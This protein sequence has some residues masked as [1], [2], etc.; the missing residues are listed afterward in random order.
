MLKIQLIITPVKFKKKTLPIIPVLVFALLIAACTGNKQ[1]NPTETPPAGTPTPTEAPMAAR[2]NGEGILLSDYEEELKRFQAGA[3]QSGEAYD[4][5]I[6]RQ[7]VLNFLVEQTLFAQAAV[8][9]GFDVNADGLQARLD[10]MTLARGGQDGLNIY[11]SENFYTTESFQ[12][13]ITRDLAVIW[14]RNYLIDQIPETAPQVHARQILVRTENEAIVIQRRLEAGTPFKDIAFEYDPL[15]G[16]ELGWF[17]RGYLFQPAVEEAA[18]SIQAGQFSG[19]I[20]TDYGYHVVEAIEVDP[21]R[22]LS[23]DALLSIQQESIETW[24]EDRKSESSIE[25]YVN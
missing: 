13:A 9:S 3:E 18:F 11:M 7:S 4:P 23:A 15:T 10:E 2:V 16:G 25:I 12:R 17:P 1:T 22:A 20:P 6:G 8:E 5:E 14:M 24:L 19:I 21:Q